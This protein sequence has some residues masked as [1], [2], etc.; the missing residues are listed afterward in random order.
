M[1]CQGG[2]HADAA[3]EAYLRARKLDRD[4]AAVDYNLGCL[5][6]DQSNYPGAIEYLTTYTSLRPREARGYL[7]LGA[8]R[9]HLGLE[10]RSALE[11]GRQF[12]AA[13]QQFE[14]AQKLEATAE[15]ANFL[16]VIELQHRSPNLQSANA[17]AEEFQLA[18]RRDP[19]FAPALLNLGVV[20]QHYLNQP[21]EAL[22]AYRQY[23]AIAPP[24]PEAKA[25][26]QLAHDLDLSLRITITPEHAPAP[27]S[28][29]AKIIPPPTNAQAP[30]PRPSPTESPPLLAARPAA[31]PAPTPA[32]VPAPRPAPTPAPTPPA[33]PAPA[34]AQPQKVP[35]PTPAPAPVVT[36][37]SENPPPLNMPVLN[38]EPPPA[39]TAP[40]PRRNLAQ[41]LNPLRWFSGKQRTAAE[42]A[43]DARARAEPPPV[44]P[45]SRY[46]YP[47]PVTPIP[48]DRAE[49]RHLAA[50]GARAHQ[51]ADF[52]RALRDYQAAVAADPTC[53]EASLGLGLTEI[54]LRDYP[55]ALEALHRA[56]GLKGDS[57]EARYAFAWTLQ[58]RGYALDAVHE[59]GP[60]RRAASGG[61]P[62]PPLAGQS[63]CRE[64][65]P[66]QTGARTIH[67]GAGSGPRKPPGSLRARLAPTAPM[68]RPFCRLQ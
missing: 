17:A 53:Y 49:A 45:G 66:D 59:V 41:K 47:P 40:P 28:P 33:A 29:P 5:R 50:D 20:L 10:E 58:K 56:L 21:R 25:V 15:G 42:S 24:P 32:P 34:P 37:P 16:G 11:K 7:R 46:N 48:G 18:L 14:A 27:A 12:E 13:R 1:A 52:S 8:A 19:H 44:P 68:S 64:T 63:L 35:E 36:P 60:L 30:R 2:G 6:M 55:A 62:R 26:E 43:A 54:D 3:S 31:V 67:R 51:A 65:G 4:N 22:K 57:V 61:S 23:P 39:Q 9:Y 38:P